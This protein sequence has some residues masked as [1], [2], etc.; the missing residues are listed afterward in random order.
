MHFKKI[1]Y[2]KVFTK[3]NIKRFISVNLGTLLVS[4]SLHYFTIP[5]KIAVGGASGFSLLVYTLTNIPIPLVLLVVNIL[6][7]IVG[8]ITIGV[9]FGAL[10]VYSSII[11]SVFL[12][13]LE[14][15]SPMPKPI[16]D[17]L[18]ITLIFGILTQSLGISIVL[19]A[20]ASTGGTDILGKI[21]EKY[22]PLS[23]GNGLMMCD[24]FITTGACIVYGTKIGMYG[25]LGVMINSFFIDKFIA[26]FNSKYNVTII[27]NEVDIIN[28][29]ILNSIHRGT[30]LYNAQGGFSHKDKTIITTIVD[31]REYIKLHRFVKKIDDKAF[32]FVSNVF[33]IEGEG[34]TYNQRTK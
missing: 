17:D 8:A 19:N 30:T 29:Y 4:L 7:I 18:F 25:L 26:G 14:K 32:L 12:A 33:E 10:T 2:S 6:L 16:I 22:T 13:F 11:C 3:H 1:D 27:S 5:A 9:T 15:F 21:I 23:F 20:G 24:G 28:D 31:R 34:F